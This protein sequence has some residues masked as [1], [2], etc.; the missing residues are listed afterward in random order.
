MVF[1][2]KN[3][4]NIRR[5]LRVGIQVESLLQSISQVRRILQRGR[6]QYPE[7]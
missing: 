6:T 3:R 4:E 2:E 7:L 1:V 5:H